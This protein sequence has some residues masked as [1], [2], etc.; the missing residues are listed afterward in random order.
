MA[1]A[2][3][4]GFGRG[5]GSDGV[6][7]WTWEAKSVN[8]RGLDIRCRVP[9]GLDQLDGQVRAAAIRHFARGTLTLSLTMAERAGAN[10]L[11]VNREALAQVLALADELGAK[12]N[13]APPRLDGLL[14]VK[15]V[16]ELGEQPAESEETLIARER[17]IISTLQDTLVTLAVS[18]ATEG[19]ALADAALRLVDAIAQQVDAAAA[20]AGSQPEAI[21]A[22]L[23]GRI[24]ELLGD[25][26]PLPSERLA[27]EVA[28]MVA[29]A[30]VRE[31]L[32]RLRAHVAQARALLAEGGAIGRR[33]DFLAQEF[34]REAN[35]LCSKSTDI[36]LTRTGLA[37]KAAVDQLREQAAN[38]E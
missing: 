36:E 11:R 32:D 12:T 27:Q 10:R 5:S 28:L 33:L 13:L 35:T 6:F 20:T 17:A 38:I 21:R 15:G 7:A 3:M 14:A 19:A 4:T 37:L 30:D 25:A 24:D 16:V 31:E 34:N 26:N 8:G 18:R 29:R 2:S 9:P 23:Q 22:R 1:I